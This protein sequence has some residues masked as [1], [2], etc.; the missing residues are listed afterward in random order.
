MDDGTAIAAA[1]EIVCPLPGVAR[2][3]QKG[4]G[5]FARKAPRPICGNWWGVGN[6]VVR[7]AHNSRAWILP[8]GQSPRAS[9][10]QS[11]CSERLWSPLCGG[12]ERRDLACR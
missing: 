2:S 5:F 6:A 1:P 8:C 3:G 12:S 7:L 9:L 10:P 11:A 4:R